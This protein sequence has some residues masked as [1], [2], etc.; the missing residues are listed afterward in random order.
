MKA[1]TQEL[2]NHGIT[3]AIFTAIA[4]WVV[5]P[6]FWMVSSSFMSQ[7]DQ[8][9]RL[10]LLLPSH[11][12]LLGWDYLI[13]NLG[14]L[15]PL[16]NSIG[17]ATIS[18][19]VVLLA[20]VLSGYALAR[21]SF[22]GKALAFNFLLLTQFVPTVANLITLF[23]LFTR[24]LHIFNTWS[25]L[26]I[27]YSSGGMI[28][29]TLLFSGFFSG[30]PVNIEEAAMI[31]GT[32]RFGAFWRVILPLMKPGLITVTTFAFIGFWGEFQIASIF[33]DSNAAKTLPVSLIQ[34]LTPYGTLNYAAQ[35]AIGTVL[36]I[37]PL[38]LF[39]CFQKYFNPS[40]TNS[41]YKG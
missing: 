16:R 19:G 13:Y 5:F 23:I 32:S 24:Y 12:S 18:T 9:T 33:T 17:I 10:P 20:T 38:V 8:H 34:L 11:I 37:P 25:G 14:L 27:I 29:G 4:I 3:Y 1:K 40:L 6:I 30:L 2:I 21:F 41:G 28:L 35:Y 36:A 7:A 31:D 22:K 26:I 39:I 15:E